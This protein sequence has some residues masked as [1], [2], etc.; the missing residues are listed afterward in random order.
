VGGDDSFE[1]RI[2]RRYIFLALYLRKPQ[3]WFPAPSQTLVYYNLNDIILKKQKKKNSG[4][5]RSDRRSQPI[6]NVDVILYDNDV[7]TNYV[8]RIHAGRTRCK[9]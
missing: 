2:F 9:R 4:I 7:Y 6:H 3:R 1:G 5:G 8:L